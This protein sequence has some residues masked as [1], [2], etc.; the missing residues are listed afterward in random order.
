MLNPKILGEQESVLL[1][2]TR[3]QSGLTP[4]V[5]NLSRDMGAAWIW[6]GQIDKMQNIIFN[7]GLALF[8]ASQPIN[9]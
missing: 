8:T 4:L 7:I 3:V 5:R 6:L 2:A 9:R 1:S